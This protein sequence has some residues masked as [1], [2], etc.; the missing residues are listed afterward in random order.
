MALEGPGGRDR[1]GVPGSVGADPWP[2]S[3]EWR[4]PIATDTVTVP[5]P[6]GWLTAAAS[7]RVHPWRFSHLRATTPS[8]GS[9]TCNSSEDARSSASAVCAAQ[10]I[11]AM[12]A[13]VWHNDKAGTPSCSR[14]SRSITQQGLFR[15]PCSPVPRPLSQQRSEPASFLP[16]EIA[17]VGAGEHLEGQVV[18]AC[19]AEGVDAVLVGPGEGRVDQAVAAALG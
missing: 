11:L 1:L 4:G 6:D 13:A 2:T 19:L 9:W 10:R 3:F 12:G 8:T 16:R 17:P 15:R 7:R 5:R 14:W 18:L